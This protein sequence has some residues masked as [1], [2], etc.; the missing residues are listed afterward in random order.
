M[1][2][3]KESRLV[4]NETWFQRLDMAIEA[5]SYLGVRLI[6]PIINM[7]DLPKWGGAATLSSWAGVQP[8]AF[9]QHNATRKLYKDILSFLAT[10]VN[11][12]TGTHNGQLC[13]KCPRYRP[14]I[15]GTC[16]QACLTGRTRP[17]WAGSWASSSSPRPATTSPPPSAAPSVVTSPITNE[18]RWTRWTR[19]RR[20]GR[21][22]WRA[23]SRHWTPTTSSSTAASPSPSPAATLSPALRH[24]PCDRS[25]PGQGS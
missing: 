15:H 3:H 12:I 25:A 21:R 13:M 7:V 2:S 11:S 20:R 5:A 8:M 14:E 24:D 16:S 10:R 6:L 4:F 18:H 22:R 9:F 17:F 19:R 23:F 1:Y